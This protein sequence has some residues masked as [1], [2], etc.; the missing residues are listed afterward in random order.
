[1]SVERLFAAPFAVGV[2]TEGDAE[3]PAVGLDW[4]PT[5]SRSFVRILAPGTETASEGSPNWLEGS[6]D[7]VAMDFHCVDLRWTG[8]PSGSRGAVWNSS[9]RIVHGCSILC[10]EIHSIRCRGLGARQGR[11]RGRN[12][13]GTTL[14][15]R[16]AGANRTGRPVDDA[17]AMQNQSMNYHLTRNRLNRCIV[18]AVS[19]LVLA[20]LV[21]FGVAQHFVV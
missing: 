19:M 16:C 13:S 2:L 20:C 9:S 5:R 18:V 4:F 8:R 1:M 14:P 3:E 11:Y 7:D 12:R 6:L 21:A 15:E 10:S 17:I